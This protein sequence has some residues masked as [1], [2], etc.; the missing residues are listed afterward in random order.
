MNEAMATTYP[1]ATN[2]RE[3]IGKPPFKYRN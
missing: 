1:D 2:I 3:V